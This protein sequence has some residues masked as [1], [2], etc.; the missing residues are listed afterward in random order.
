M[1]DALLVCL[2]TITCYHLGVWNVGMTAPDSCPRHIHGVADMLW[3]AA[4]FTQRVA[5]RQ[6][7]LYHFQ[8]LIEGQREQLIKQEEDIKK[9]VEKIGSTSDRAGKASKEQ[10]KEREKELQDKLDKVCSGPIGITV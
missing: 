10:S 2:N 8:Q 5:G 7:M 6:W 1:P 4:L 9:Q 3:P